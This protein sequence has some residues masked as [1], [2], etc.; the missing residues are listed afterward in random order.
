MTSL[1][2][3]SDE[4]PWALTRAVKAGRLRKLA[5]KIYT[6]DLR[7]P[8]EQIILQHRLRIAAHFYPQ[9]VIS[10]RSALEGS[11][12][13]SEGGTL[14]LSVPRKLH[15]RRVLPGLE[16]CLHYGPGP[17]KDDVRTVFDD[18]GQPTLYTASQPRFLLENLQP[19]RRSR[20]GESASKTVSQAELEQWLERQILVFGEE[21][22]RQL[23][24]QTQQL[25][26]R[27]EWEKEAQ[28]LSALVDALLGKSSPLRLHSEPARAR[29]ARR[30][31][32]AQRVALFEGLAARLAAEAFAE[33]PFPSASEIQLRAFWE[34]YFSNFIE[35][36]RFTPEE[37]RQLVYEPAEAS[38]LLAS[39]PDDA[40]DVRESWNLITDSTLAAATPTDPQT[41]LDLLKLR[42]ARL[43]AQRPH[44]APGHFKTQ[45][46]QF[47]SRLFV[48][49]ELVEETLRRALMLCR[50]LPRPQGRAFFL[51][52]AIAE[53]H[54]FADG[55][56]RLSRLCMNAELEHAELQRLIIPTSL[57]IDYLAVLEALTL[58]GDP[59]PFVAF[60]HRLVE[61]NRLFPFA[62]FETSHRYFLK[63]GAF[64]E[65]GGALFDLHKLMPDSGTQA[66]N[67]LDGPLAQ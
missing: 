21:W 6:S 58:R 37:A 7:S 13:A 55:N 22:L 42:H 28:K 18:N 41:F 66:A 49:P 10:H 65:S 16:L 39:R 27:L 48:A 34:S 62:D 8:P 32:D 29:A 12:L 4:K 14:H 15:P 35:G 30:P 23:Q 57:R 9:A 50:A 24:I 54:P 2:F 67:L 3:S 45:N 20:G 40:H 52:F 36:T 33:T 59:S 46:N 1:Y 63:T 60:A 44:T 38:R 19:S 64:E 5:P 47:G 31:Y 61:I 26:A 51:L 25:G 17:Q 11:I 56:G 53:V 43:M